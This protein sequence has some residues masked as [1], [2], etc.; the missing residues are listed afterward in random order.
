MHHA[1]ANQSHTSFLLEL[2]FYYLT[3]ARR[4]FFRKMFLVSRSVALDG[5]FTNAIISLA[6]IRRQNKLR[7]NSLGDFS[8]FLWKLRRWAKANN[9]TV[10]L[11]MVTRAEMLPSRSLI[12][13]LLQ[14]LYVSTYREETFSA[15]PHIFIFPNACFTLR[16]WN[17]SL[18][19]CYWALYI[20][21]I[22]CLCQCRL[23]K[24]RLCC[25]G[26]CCVWFL[27]FYRLSWHWHV[28]KT[29]V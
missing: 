28:I 15:S 5:F 7:T 2:F 4:Y 17:N 19:M 1:R 27:S 6:F 12:L 23:E 14:L 8:S 3:N 29:G 24:V 21:K 16:T 22:V 10:G 20:L 11:F 25:R 26:K 18:E 9:A 13:H